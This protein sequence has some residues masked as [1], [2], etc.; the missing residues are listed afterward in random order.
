MGVLPLPSRD[1][2]DELDIPRASG[3]GLFFFQQLI[4]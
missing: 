2:G 3:L 1:P 4:Q